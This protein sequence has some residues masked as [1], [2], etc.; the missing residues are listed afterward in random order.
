MTKEKRVATLKPGNVFRDWLVEVLGDRI[1]KKKSR[2]KVYKLT[3]SS[4]TVC[5]YEFEDDGYSVISKFYGEPTGW[6]VDCNPAWVMHE[7]FETLKK[8]EQ[9]I[10]IPKPIC[11]KKPARSYPIGIP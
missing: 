10:D 11:P 2:V 5:R 4:H 8:V 9:V 1:R 3:P 7:E 6:K